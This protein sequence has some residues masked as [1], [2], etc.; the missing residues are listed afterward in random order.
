MFDP[1]DNKARYTLLSV[2]PLINLYFKLPSSIKIAVPFHEI[3]TEIKSESK[4][5]NIY[6]YA[7]Y[8]K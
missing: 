3:L 1:L 7:Y 2:I 5:A 4:F 6:C 8:D